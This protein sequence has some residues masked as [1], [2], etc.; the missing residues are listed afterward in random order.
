[1]HQPS[2]SFYSQPGRKGLIDR[3]AARLSG[4]NAHSLTLDD[5]FYECDRRGVAADL[6]PMRRAH[7]LFFYDE[8][9][10]CIA[11]NRLISEPEQIVAAYHELTHL[12]DHA[13]D[14]AVFLSVGD[15]WN[16]HRFETQA[17]II[18]V[19]ALM[20]DRAVYGATAGE[21]MER[22]GVSRAIA[23]FRLSLMI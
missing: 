10:A 11:I 17:N 14:P 3:F 2:F 20:P 12:L 6:I 16:H 4:F 9:E 13:A 21:L 15:L 8:G 1:M 7:G 5:F 22:F 18:G 23:E 19:I